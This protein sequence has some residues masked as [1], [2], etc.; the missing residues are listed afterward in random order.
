MHLH[1]LSLCAIGPF[2]SSYAIDFDRLTQSGLFLL[3]G[4]T[5]AGK[6]SI[7]DAVVFA[8]YGKVAA[9]NGSDGRMYSDFAKAGVE[10]YVELDF[11]TSSGRFRVRRTPKYERPKQRGSGTTT[12]N[13]TARLW[14]LH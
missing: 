4:P 6:S 10:P 2:A 1:R 11:S 13:S 9:R 14:Q 5:G 8:L 12:Q 7:I 3:Q